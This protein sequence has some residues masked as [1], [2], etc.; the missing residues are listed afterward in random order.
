MSEKKLEPIQ[1]SSWKSLWKETFES[2]KSKKGKQ[3]VSN[4]TKAK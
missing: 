3:N 1:N 2:G 4:N